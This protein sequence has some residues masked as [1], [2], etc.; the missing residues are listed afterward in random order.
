[1][2]TATVTVVRVTLFSINILMAEQIAIV[3]IMVSVTIA[4]VAVS[5]CR[6]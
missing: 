1:M 5:G 6:R 4:A 2:A 3:S